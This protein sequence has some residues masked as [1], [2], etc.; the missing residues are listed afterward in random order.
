MV[1][2]HFKRRVSEKYEMKG[3]IRSWNDK[4]KSF[5]RK[6]KMIIFYTSFVFVYL[7]TITKKV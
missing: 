7:I 2:R 5:F 4:N 3:N 6:E 1:D